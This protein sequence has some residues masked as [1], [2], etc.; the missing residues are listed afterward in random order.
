MS[1]TE[2]NIMS[3]VEE[4]TCACPA[5][6]CTKCVTVT[7][8]EDELKLTEEKYAQILDQVRSKSEELSKLKEHALVLSGARSV[9]MKVCQK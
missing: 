7:S 4:E 8:I 6:C 9:L 1:S 2:T 3:T 5:E